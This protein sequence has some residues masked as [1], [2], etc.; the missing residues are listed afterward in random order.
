MLMSYLTQEYDNN[1]MILY[2]HEWINVWKSELGKRDLI[3]SLE[4]GFPYLCVP[5]KKRGENP[6]TPTY[7]YKKYRLYTELEIKPLL[8]AR[9]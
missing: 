3:L 6:D 4:N 8:D 1:Y 2:K 5:V 9:K 7:T